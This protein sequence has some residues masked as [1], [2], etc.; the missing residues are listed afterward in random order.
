[1]TQDPLARLTISVPRPD[2]SGAA[3]TG[4]LHLM[5]SLGT[6][7]IKQAKQ[8]CA[9]C[10]VQPACLAYATANREQHGIWGGRNFAALP[11]FD[12]PEAER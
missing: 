5:F 8:L 9:S 11:L 4:Q 7:E 3:C 2:L 1:M 12:E 10:P 6:S